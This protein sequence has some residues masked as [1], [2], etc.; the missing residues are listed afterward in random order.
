VDDELKYQAETSAYTG[1]FIMYSGKTKI[2][3]W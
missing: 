1:R 3:Y 2:Y